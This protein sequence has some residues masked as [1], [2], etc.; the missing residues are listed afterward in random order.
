MKL[1]NV[2]MAVAVCAIFLLIAYQAD[3]PDT[4]LDPNPMKRNQ[5]QFTRMQLTYDSESVK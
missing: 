2:M 5:E 3:A 1:L 4:T